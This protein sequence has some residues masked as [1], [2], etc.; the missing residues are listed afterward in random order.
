MK[1]ALKASNITLSAKIAYSN[2]KEN[3][4]QVFINEFGTFFCK[5]GNVY[6]DKKD[7]SI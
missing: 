5:L 4:L 6:F 1:N 3:K 7:L 2:H